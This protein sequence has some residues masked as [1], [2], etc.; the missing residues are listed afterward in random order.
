MGRRKKVAS[1][2]RKIRKTLTAEAAE[3]VEV[4]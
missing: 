1:E 2:E 4:D 3:G